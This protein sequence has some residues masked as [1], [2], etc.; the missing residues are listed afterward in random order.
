ML[1]DHG[2]ELRERG[3]GFVFVSN[4][5]IGVK[6]SSIDRALSKAN[7]V[8]RFGG[9]VGVDD[10]T[11]T[12]N[13][14]SK[15]Y[16]PRPLRNKIDTSKLY[17][18]YTKEQNEA[19]IQG[20]NQWNKPV[21]Y[22]HLELCEKLE[23]KYGLTPDNHETKKRGAQGRASNIEFKAGSESL[24]GWMQQECLAQIQAATSWTELHQVL[25][26]V[27]YTHLSPDKDI[28]NLKK[29]GISFN[30]ACQI[31]ENDVFTWIDKRKD[32]N[33]T[34]IISIGSLDG[35]IIIVVVHTDRNGITRI[36]SCLLYTST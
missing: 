3:N 12:K 11:T 9:Y 20:K 28:T 33:E 25:K 18:Q 8:K 15:Q 23:Q 5:G 27:S 7:L 26:A 2:L 29:H 35:E 22:T 31:F 36:I 34:R 32:Y 1:K 16:E 4:N 21:S 6:A 10:D 14:Y 17:A 13:Q 30:E 19:A 24:I